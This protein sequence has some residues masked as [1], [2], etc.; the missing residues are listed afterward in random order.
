[1]TF[2]KCILLLVFIFHLGGLIPALAP[3]F[4][5]DEPLLS[6]QEVQGAVTQLIRVVE[7]DYIRRVVH[8]S[9]FQNKSSLF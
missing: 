5:A 9:I 3:A 1:M 8:I 6:E 2:A 7:K 4:G